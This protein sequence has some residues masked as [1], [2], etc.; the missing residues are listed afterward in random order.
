MATARLFKNGSS[1]AV[2]L[3]KDYRFEG[4][5]VAIRRFGDAVI[6]LPL[7]YRKEDLMGLLAEIGPVELAPRE[8]DDW[9]D[10][11]A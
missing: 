11:R 3:P 1:Q 5:E 7:R 4:E 6:L 8:Q 2:R 9:N 10:Q